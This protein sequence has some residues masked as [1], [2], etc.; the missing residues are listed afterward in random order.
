MR[1]P[2]PAGADPMSRTRAFLADHAA[3]YGLADPARDLA[4]VRWSSADGVTRAVFAQLHEGLP[5]SGARIA[6]H[7]HDD[8]VLMTIGASMTR[9]PHVDG[10]LLQGRGGVCGRPERE[11]P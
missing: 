2:L 1:V 3:L 5:V 11:I 10:R 6:V 4:P 8:Q 9:K 7:S